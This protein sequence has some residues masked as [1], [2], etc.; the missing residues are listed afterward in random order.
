MASG[1]LERA[2]AEVDA[3]E[4]VGDGAAAP[5][6]PILLPKSPISVLRELPRE[7]IVRNRRAGTH[8]FH[9]KGD[10]GIWLLFA[11][12]HAIVAEMP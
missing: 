3:E 12:A 11:R 5:P 2:A 4:P 1:A 7:Q 8:L 10:P 6:S 9:E